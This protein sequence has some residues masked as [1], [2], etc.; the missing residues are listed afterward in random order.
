[1]VWRFLKEFDIPYCSM[2]DRGYTSIGNVHTTAPNPEL[3]VVKD[4]MVS[5]QPAWM[6]TDAMLE[7][8]GRQKVEDADTGG[9]GN[10]KQL[11]NPNG[12]CSEDT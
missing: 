6:L 7:R 11:A 10:V 1:M 4:G 5:F 8:A 9:N 12:S 3:A 2:Y